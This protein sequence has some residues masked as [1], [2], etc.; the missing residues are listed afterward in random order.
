MIYSEEGIL[1]V[2][3]F[4]VLGY[5]LARGTWHLPQKVTLFPVWTQA[6]WTVW[7][8]IWKKKILK[9]CIK[10]I[11]WLLK[12]STVRL[13]WRNFPYFINFII[14]YLVSSLYIHTTIL[15]FLPTLMIKITMK[16][17]SSQTNPFAY[18]QI[19]IQT[20]IP[21]NFRQIFQLLHSK[22]IIQ[23]SEKTEVCM[24]NWSASQWETGKTSTSL[25]VT[26]WLSLSI[27]MGLLQWLC[28]TPYSTFGY[29]I[30]MDPCLLMSLT[31]LFSLEHSEQNS[32]PQRHNRKAKQ[33]VKFFL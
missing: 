3:N 28:G 29:S 5:C 32:V 20:V 12:A 9:H 10:Y 15:T 6:V 13:L 33:I 25:H 19:D 11:Q 4:P 26:Q 31:P 1:P 22:K 30:N 14:F 27:V 7:T 17:W 8:E 18:R 21:Q 24:I 23:K 16:E 2:D